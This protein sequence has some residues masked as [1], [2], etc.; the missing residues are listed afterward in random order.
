MIAA[1]SSR[2]PR[3]VPLLPL[4]NGDMLTLTEFLLRYEDMTGVKKAQLIEGVVHMPSPVRIAHAEPDGVIQGWLFTYA[5]EHE[6][7]IFPNA[8]LLLDP[9]NAFQPDAILCTAPQPG[10]RVW[11]NKKGYLCGS[12]ELVVEIAAS[13]ASIDLRDKLRV[14]RR[15]EVAEYL[16]WRTADQEIDWFVLED[17]QY[18]KMKPDRHGKLR[19]RVFPG[20]VLDLAA[21]LACDKARVLAS[22]RR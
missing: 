1:A 6:L 2:R 21:A 9:E 7:K 22:L 10:G 16:V 4:E 18:V 14:Y 15:L 3:S 11:L 12:P 19:S 17:G 13:T 5:A 8:T 20:L